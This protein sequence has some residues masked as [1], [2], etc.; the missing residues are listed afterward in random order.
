MTFVK[1]ILIFV[2]L[3][4]V[5]IG[6]KPVVNA[7]FEVSYGHLKVAST[8]DENHPHALYDYESV[9]TEDNEDETEF[10]HD[11]FPIRILTTLS[12][13]RLDHKCNRW[14]QYTLF[15]QSR[16]LPVYLMNRNLLI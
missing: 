1:S 8:D 11:F 14:I 4:L 7:G 15:T 13:I 3:H 9:R 5:L 2:S 10:R 16:S 12:D 6:F